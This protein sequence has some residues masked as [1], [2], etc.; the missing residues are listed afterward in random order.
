MSPQVK[1]CITSLAPYNN[2]NHSKFILDNH[3]KILKLDSNESTISPSPHVTGELIRFIQE[4]PLNLYPDVAS[5]ELIE[6]LSEYVG[7]PRETILT[8]NGS[9]H[10]LETICRSYLSDGDD[11]LMFV[12]T[13]DHFR[14][15]AQSSGANILKMVEPEEKSLADCIDEKYT[16]KLKMVYLVNPNNPTGK[17]STAPSILSATQKHP[18]LLF[19]IDEAYF[20]F[21][22][23]TVAPFVLTQKNLIVTRSFSKA[24]GLAGLRCRFTL[25][26]SDVK[27]ELSKIR[28][29]KNINSLAQIAAVAALTDIDYMKRYVEDVRVDK[30]WLISE[31]EKLSIPVKNTPA[32]FILIKV[33]NTER[34]IKFLEGENIYLRDR[35]QVGMNGTIR[36]TVGDPLSMKRFWK[37]FKQ[38]PFEWLVKAA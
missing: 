27:H 36:I 3:K 5:E 6:R 14:V 13:Y 18:D 2:G 19:V 11:C 8:F 38:I 33:Q 34:V 35:S 10:A 25:S 7:L 1:K 21:S 37:I 26:H 15:F 16:S 4:G 20:E 28:V 32:N 31:M 17:L 23:Q 22:E 30:E 12:P 24:F 29:G 9:D